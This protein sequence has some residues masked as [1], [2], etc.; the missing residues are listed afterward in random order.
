MSVTVLVSRSVGAAYNLTTIELALIFEPGLLRLLA[1]RLASV[2][3]AEVVKLPESIRW[4][5]KIPDR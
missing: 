1:S 3:P 4:Q 5:H 2:T